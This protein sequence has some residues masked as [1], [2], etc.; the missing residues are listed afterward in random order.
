MRVNPTLRRP[1]AL[2]VAAVATSLVTAWAG[3]AAP[4]AVSAEVAAAAATS[5]IDIPGRGADVPFVEHEAET[6]AT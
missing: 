2:G 4:T 1:L 6:A 3:A 5:P